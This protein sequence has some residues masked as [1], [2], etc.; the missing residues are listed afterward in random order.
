MDYLSLYICF[1]LFSTNQQ[2]FF[3]TLNIYILYHDFFDF[4]IF[5]IIKYGLST[6]RS[7]ITP[8]VLEN[9]N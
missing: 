9:Q 1:I 4:S 3:D 8:G 5:V 2:L 6:K 7:F